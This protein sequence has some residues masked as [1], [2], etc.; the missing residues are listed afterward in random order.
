MLGSNIFRIS[1][2][3]FVFLS[4][5]WCHHE[6]A[7][8]WD[9]YRSYYKEGCA[10]WAARPHGRTSLP[11]SPMWPSGPTSRWRCVIPAPPPPGNPSCAGRIS[12]VCY[13]CGQTRGYSVAS[14]T[15]ELSLMVLMLSDQV[16]ISHGSCYPVLTQ[17]W[18]ICIATAPELPPGLDLEYH[19]NSRTCGIWQTCSS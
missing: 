7:V 4:Y 5:N 12:T 19:S 18:I 17:I 14:L 13:E 11:F 6:W 1:A 10:N 2:A 8:S 9:F 3:P 16:V 15:K